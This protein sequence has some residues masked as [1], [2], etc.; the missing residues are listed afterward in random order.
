MNYTVIDNFLPDNIFK[1]IK[2]HIFSKNFA[3]S[4]SPIV[5]NADEI[6]TKEC[7]IPSSYYFVHTFFD[8]FNIDP[9][10][11]K[12]GELFDMIECK[13][14]LRVKS[15]LYPSTSKLQYHG[16][17]FDYPFEHKGAVLSLN[18]NDGFTVLDDNTHIESVE[19]RIVIF[20]S[21]KL[22]RSTTCTNTKCRINLNINFF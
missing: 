14:L 5:A 18:S 11:E 20:D 1:K 15:N 2:D 22:H 12:F 10:F 6:N 16:W 7:D 19:N 8:K 4:L 21:A 17:H 13:S 3:W 9:S